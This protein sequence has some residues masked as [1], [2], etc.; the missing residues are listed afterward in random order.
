MIDVDAEDLATEVEGILRE[1]GC[2][3]LQGYLYAKP[4]SAKALALWATDDVGPRALD[5]RASLFSETA[6]AALS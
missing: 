4:M 5:F 6:P 1:L 3:E 2:H